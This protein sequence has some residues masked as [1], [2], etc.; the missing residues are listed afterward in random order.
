L[1]E[2]V[3]HL[4][5]G[6]G[7]E[8]ADPRQPFVLAAGEQARSGEAPLH[9]DADLRILLRRQRLFEQRRS[10]CRGMAQRILRRG[11]PRRAIRAEQGQRAERR[12]DRAA[13]PVVDDDPI[14]AVWSDVRDWLPRRGIADRGA[15]ASI[16]D[17]DDAPIGR[18][19]QPVAPERL[20]DRDGANLAA[21]AERCDRLF[22]CRETVASESGDNRRKILRLRRC[23]SDKE[24]Q[25]KPDE[26]RKAQ[27]S[28]S[29][30]SPLLSPSR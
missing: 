15:R 30:Y 17:N 12:L 26:T 8:G 9:G 14:E 21:L 3:L 20:Q 11:E 1:A 29:S 4:R 6:S 10:F 25:R 7:A 22:L 2:E 19:A 27:H 18:F 13:Q 23:G 28:R 16:V 5:I 24:D